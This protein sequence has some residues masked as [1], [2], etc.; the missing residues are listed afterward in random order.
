MLSENYS[1]ILILNNIAQYIMSTRQ[2]EKQDLSFTFDKSYI[3]FMNI[4]ITKIKNILYTKYS[5][6]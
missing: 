6:K 1:K 2:F 3:T 5:Q 4:I